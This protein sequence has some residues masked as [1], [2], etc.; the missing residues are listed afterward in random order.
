MYMYTYE[1]VTEALGVAPECPEAW[2]P[3]VMETHEKLLELCDYYVVEQVKIKFGGLRYY[4]SVDYDGD[5]PEALL[6]AMQKVV[7]E[8]ELKVP[9]LQL[10]AYRPSWQAS[11]IPKRQRNEGVMNANEGIRLWAI[12]K[13]EK[14]G[15]YLEVTDTTLVE[16]KEQEFADG[17]CETCYYEWTG[18]AVVVDGEVLFE[19][20]ESFSEVMEE[21]L[22]LIKEKDNELS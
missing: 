3:V 5:R 15:Y 20:Y 9:K 19:I 16:V 10:T 8:A 22:E 2:F 1:E 13:A 17:Y 6:D 11:S 14:Y 4:F 18:L 21:V 12:K 7:D